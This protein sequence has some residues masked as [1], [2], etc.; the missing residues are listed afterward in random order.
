[1]FPPEPICA[2]KIFESVALAVR[3]FES[4]LQKSSRAYARLRREKNPNMIFKDIKAQPDK[5]VDLLFKPVEAKIVEV[6]REDSALVLDQSFAVQE[7]CPL[8][9]NGEMVEVIHSEA[10]C[11][12]AE[13]VTN[14]QP[15]DVITQIS[16]VGTEGD[17]FDAF[18]N[19]WR[20]K[21][22]R[23]ADIPPDRWEV[24]LNFARLKLP[25]VHM[26]WP[27]LDPESLREILAQKKTATSHGLDGV[28]LKDLKSLLRSIQESTASNCVPCQISID[29]ILCII[30]GLQTIQL[31]LLD[32]VHIVREC[33]YHGTTAHLLLLLQILRHPLEQHS[34]FI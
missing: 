29:T 19:A 17:L 15:G 8:V 26:Q 21:W 5:G 10:D 7:G 30:R 2:T 31:H 25:H 22:G 27:S 3:A 24:I 23:H 20:E 4:Q 11:I 18:M 28:T 1:M 13:N 12:W 6:S 34:V 33:S 14:V 32:D 9:C 16:R